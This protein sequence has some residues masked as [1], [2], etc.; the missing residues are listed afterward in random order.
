MPGTIE[1][2][3]NQQKMAKGKNK[4]N[5]IAR[6]PVVVVL[7][8]ID[9][10]KT[11]LLDQ[12]RKTQI[13]EKEAGGITQHIGA[14]QVEK[15]GKKITF[16]DTPGHEAF[17]Q[18]RSRG[19]KTADIALLIIDSS[20]GVESQTKE[21]IS[22]IKKA[23]I[24]QIVVLNKIDR[25]GANP[26]KAEGELQKENVM[27]E[28]LGGKIPSIEI[29][30]K[31][32]QGVED[33][34]DLILLVAEIEDL[35]TDVSKSAKGVI[36]ESYLDGKRGPTATLILNEGT[37]R[38]GDIIATPSSS[39]KIKILE[40]FQGEKID[41]VLPADPAI[42]LGLENVPRVGEEFKV[43]TD[44]EK[45]QSHLVVK[46]PKKAEEPKEVSEAKDDQK[47]LNLILKTDVLGSI[48]AIEEVLKQLPQEKI[49]LNIL[50]SEVG[51]INE[52][53][54]KLAKGAEALIL[55]FRVKTNAVIKD[56][57]QRQKIRIMNFEIIYDLVEAARKFMEKGLKLETVRIDLG[58]IKV[59]VSFWGTRKR[60]IVGGRITEGKVERRTSIEVSRDEEIID[61]G[62]MI[63]LQKNKKDIEKASKGEEVGILY[64]GEK[65][66]EKGDVLTIYRKEQQKAEL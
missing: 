56:L 66:I 5:L 29:S 43:F 6:P 31:T 49:V 45:A 9:S 41:E 16:I 26:K 57:A 4:E 64:E 54:V 28:S 25:P 12:I 38:V 40:D 2:E 34:L 18:M 35:K 24:P 23:N 46:E 37:L 36:I 32:G 1:L 21:V 22:H 39:G 58:K 62:K 17:S 60:Q 61:K 13:T 11:T 51:D 19:A 63:N 42:V 7:G 30:A 33:L 59:L 52:N 55:G 15:D 10:G 3:V 20:K 53:D 14:Y 47:V 48:E 8:H 65:K 27:V 50:K 44:L